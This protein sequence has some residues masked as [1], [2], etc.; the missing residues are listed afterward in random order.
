MLSDKQ[1][2]AFQALYKNHFGKEISLKESY[3]KGIK[4]A[5]LVELVYKPM[6]KED[7]QR[8]KA[9]QKETGGLKD[10]KYEIN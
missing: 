10:K 4:L 9:R 8:L 7:Y 1:T 2:I 3:E 6:E 5:R